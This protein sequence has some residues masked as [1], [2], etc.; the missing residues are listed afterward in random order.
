MKGKNSR[1]IIIAAI[2]ASVLIIDQSLKFWVKLNMY[3][4]QEK[5]LFGLDWARLH[6]TENPGMAWGMEL[7]GDYGKLIL[8][9]FRILAVIF[10]GIYL[11]RLVKEKAGKGLLVSIALILA[12][13]IGN[14]IDSAFYGLIFSGSTHGGDVATLFPDGGGYTSFLH[15]YVVDMFYFPVYQGYMPEWLPFIGGDYFIFFQPIFNVADV[16][17]SLGVFLI[18]IFYKQF[19]KATQKDPVAEA[20]AE[21]ELAPLTISEENSNS[22]EKN[23]EKSKESNEKL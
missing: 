12:G 5:L 2:I 7:G 6:F 13:A 8:S 16:A 22:Q 18:L 4:G 20:T 21:G 14:I 9:L 15:G 1:S 10:I 3:K 17:I 11:S 23:G 19:F